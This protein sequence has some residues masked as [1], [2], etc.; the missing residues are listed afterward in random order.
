MFS[1]AYNHIV[2]EEDLKALNLYS[3]WYNKDG[4][5]CMG[6]NPKYSKRKS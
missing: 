6:L 1:S 5:K 4:L 2:A 3:K